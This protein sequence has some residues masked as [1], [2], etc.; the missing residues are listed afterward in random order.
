MKNI[1]NHSKVMDQAF[2]KLNGD[3]VEW[4][5]SKVNDAL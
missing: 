4:E 1:G 3:I 2:E 5:K